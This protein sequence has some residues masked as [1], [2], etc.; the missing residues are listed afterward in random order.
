MTRAFATAALLACLAA[1]LGAAAQT[2]NPELAR[3]LLAAYPMDG[4]TEDQVTGARARAFALRPTDGH[5]GRQ[6]GA[7]WFDGQRSFMDLAG[8]LGPDVFTVSAWIRPEPGRE[9]QVVISKI[10]DVPQHQHRNFELRVGP[11]GKMFLHVPSGR[12]WDAVEGRLQIPFGRWSHVAATYDGASA[13]LWVNGVRDGA[14]LMVRY[15]QS[16]GPVFVGARP[17]GG[18]RRPSGPVFLFQGGIEDVRIWDR[19]LSEGEMLVVAGRAPVRPPPPPPPPPRAELLAR[20]PLEVDG[21]DTVGQGGG[22]MVGQELQQAEDHLGRPRGA[23]DF[24]GRGYVELGVRTMP[25]RFSIAAW[26]L[27]QRPEVEEQVILSTNV[28]PGIPWDRHLELRVERGGRLALA[29]P[30]LPHDQALRGARQLQPGRWAFVVATFDGE[31]G[32]LYVDG[33]P[34]AEGRVPPFEVARGPTLLGARPDRGGDSRPWTGWHGRLE[35]VQIFRG[36]LP[37]PEVAALY[38][39]SLGRPRNPD[40]DDGR[41][42]AGF[43]TKVDRLVLRWDMACASGDGQALVEVEGLIVRELQQA[44]G[45]A[46]AEG[47]DK[48]AGYLRRASAEMEGARGQRHPRALDRK[49]MAMARLAEALWGDLVEELPGEGLEPG[50]PGAP[51]RAGRWY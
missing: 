16:P 21:R 30:S 6:G 45:A 46:R 51:R 18:G 42:E 49:R 5:D 20:Y 9:P 36:V 7:L 4:D 29:L 10:R 11:S 1:P 32:V 50:R 15:A 31:R 26:V 35:D 34:D 13:Q 22:R 27:L 8:Q 25:E 3:G 43:L 33:T 48:I 37:A 12:G 41:A 44:E 28:A 14:P 47:N 19:P 23:L 38:Q 39:S 24:G 17:E 2:R 40:D